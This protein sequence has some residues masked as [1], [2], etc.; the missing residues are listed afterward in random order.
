[1]SDETPDWKATLP[2]DIRA[3]PSLQSFKD[4]AALARSHVEV[5][6]LVGSSIRPPG[7]DA[8]PE[9]RAEF[10]GKFTKDFPELVN[11][12]DE[13]ALLGALG[14]PEDAKE[15]AP[16]KDVELPENMVAEVRNYAKE[17]GLTKKQAEALFKASASQY[18]QQ[19]EAVGKSQQELKTEWGAALEERTKLAASAAEKMGFPTAAIEVIK[20]GRGSAAEMKGFYAMAKA[21]GLDKPGNTLATQQGGTSTHITPDEARDR[22]NEIRQRKEYWNPGLN[23]REHERL[24]KQVVKLT[25]LANAGEE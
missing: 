17:A 5:Q 9:K 1:M 24:V 4:V 3:A 25:E 19:Q 2:E 20:S 22:L 12:K 14:R 10:L 8:P 21:L 7:P 23:P 13:N 11:S 15:Y 18:Q 16:P 6:K